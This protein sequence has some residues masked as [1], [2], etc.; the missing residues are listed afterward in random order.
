ML[1]AILEFYIFTNQY[2]EIKIT[3][4]LGCKLYHQI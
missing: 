2:N 3:V 1:L 4:E